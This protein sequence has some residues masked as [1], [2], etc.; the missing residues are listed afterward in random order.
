MD[1]GR[2]ARERFDGSWFDGRNA[3][4]Q[5]AQLD[6]IGTDLLLWSRTPEPA[7]LQ[8]VEL[9]E[10]QLSEPFR[11]APMQLVFADGGT[12]EV[13]DNAGLVRALS[14]QGW[15]PS[16]VV[17]L[18]QRWPAAVGAL[19]LLAL[20]ALLAWTRGVPAAAHWLAFNLP[21]QLEQRIGAELMRVLDAHHLK[22]STLDPARQT[23]IEQQFERAAARAAPEVPYRLLFRDVPGEGGVNAFALPGGTI[24]LLDGMSGA[25]AKLGLTEAEI[26]AVLGH[27]LGHVKHK[28]GLRRLLQTA[29]IGVLSGLLWGDFAGLAA[30]MPVAL[31][32]LRYSRDFEREADDFAIAFLELN[33]L[34]PTPLAELFRKLEAAHGGRGGF[35]STHPSPRER[36]ERAEQSR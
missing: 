25:D 36:R 27:E 8:R 28:H 2:F 23:A 14:A 34:G 24:V 1:D 9:A 3:A 6:L 11:N 30:N 21:P 31:G 5:P 16:R 15:Q 12:L 33:G 22:P 13:P 17:R 35:F 10:V 4:G 26:L 20:L 7:L 18:Q 32:F 29:G 19:V